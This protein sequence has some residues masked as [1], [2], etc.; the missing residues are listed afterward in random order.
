MK[1]GLKINKLTD[2]V[3]KDEFASKRRTALGIDISEGRI[4]LALLKKG[5]NGV[6]LV[7]SAGEPVPDGAIKGGKAKYH[8]SF[9]SFKELS[10]I[11][12]IVLSTP[13]EISHMCGIIFFPP[14]SE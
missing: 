12:N 4:S 5:A 8:P 9:P 13:A 10:K 1:L 11:A 3:P 14:S 2:R 7:K 6:K